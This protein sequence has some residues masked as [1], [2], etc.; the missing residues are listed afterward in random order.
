MQGVSHT[1][2]CPLLSPYRMSSAS[3]ASTL[4]CAPG[5]GGVTRQPTQL[6]AAR[7]DLLRSLRERRTRRKE[8]S[9]DGRLQ[10][11]SN[12]GMPASVMHRAQA[13]Q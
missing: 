3:V 12:T 8:A 6:S 5:G 7:G 2:A 13:E 9:G 10:E 11:Q 1:L 4:Y